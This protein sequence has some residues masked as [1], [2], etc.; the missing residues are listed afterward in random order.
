MFALRYGLT[1][2][3]LMAFA[4]AIVV[5]GW[6]LWL[7]I[8]ITV[9]VGGVADEVSGDDAARLP[10]A[11]R[12]FY[13]AN[14]HAT[15]P[16]IGI[17]TFLY[18]H[19]LTPTDPFGFIRRLSSVGVPFA[20]AGSLT[21]IGPLI[22][23]TLAL[24]IFYALAAVT[25][26]HELIHRPEH[27]A[28]ATGRA[29]LAF[30]FNTQF[31]ISHI[32]VHHRYVGT[33][34]DSATARRGQHVFAFA[35]HAIVKGA[36]EAFEHEARR[37]QRRGSTAWTWR[38]Q[39]LRGQCYSL[40]IL[41]AAAVVAG[42]AGVAGIIAAAMIGRL[43]HETI[44]Y[45]QHYG[46]VRV[47]GAPLASRHAWDCYRR[48]SNALHYN[49][50]RHA[51]HHMSASKPFW[52]LEAAGA[53]LLPHGY[54]TMALIALVPP[55]WHRKLEPLLDDWDRRLASEDERRLLRVSPPGDPHAE[56]SLNDTTELSTELSMGH[57]GGD[58]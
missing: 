15:L 34:R 41:A 4:A 40:A 5:G 51:D 42:A 16:L 37:L 7:V 57:E 21:Q 18:L 2:A 12:W 33:A 43:L 1:S 56:S 19:L 3:L 6:S 52:Q 47:E 10:A 48:I 9:L 50:P 39:A 38:N 35:L 8:L 24:G 45:V 49:L 14:L 53:P 20:A 36:Y 55:L 32:H 54:Q 30:T 44:N 58:R 17:V 22:A 23:A 11:G 31:A 13:E 25:A 29:L 46:L 27:V 28:F 26:G